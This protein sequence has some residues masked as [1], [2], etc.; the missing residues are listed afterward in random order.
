[1][2]DSIV[3]REF[4]ATK[5]GV[6]EVA[7][8]FVSDHYTELARFAIQQRT[9]VAGLIENWLD[10]AIVDDRRAERRLRMREDV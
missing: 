10:E 5:D 3:T 1:M 4:E 7:D 9:S 2:S 8:K 6:R